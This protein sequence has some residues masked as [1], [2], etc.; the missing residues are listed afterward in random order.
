MYVICKDRILKGGYAM[1]LNDRKKSA[2]LLYYE[3]LNARSV[4]SNDERKKYDYLKKGYVGECEYD[5]ILD[6]V[7]HENLFVYRDIYL[8]INDVITQYDTLLINDDGVVV[9]EVKNY[10]GDYLYKTGN[11]YKSNYQLSE[12]PII[13][14]KRAANKIIKIS[15]PN[16]QSINV[17]NKVVFVNDDFFL[18]SDDDRIWNQ[19]CVRSNLRRYLRSMKRG[20]LGKK[21]SFH[22]ENI[23]NYIVEEP[24]FKSE[25]NFERLKLGLYCSQ[26]GSFNLDKKRFHF[27]CNKCGY[28]ESSENYLL[29]TMSEFKFL[30]YKQPMTK[31]ALMKLVD[32]QISSSVMEKGLKKFCAIKGMSVKSNYTFKFYSFEEANQYYYD[33]LRYKNYYS[34]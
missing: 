33:K 3:A 19:I 18:E 30:F 4:L 31:S 27:K 24:Y 16:T 6:N 32:N 11:W 15:K 10:S 29:R 5:Q 17:N 12:D 26:C 34:H 8:K 7:G 23:N 1:F 21:S 9:N 13:Q 25:I 28:L 14:V 20:Q 22:V 2:E